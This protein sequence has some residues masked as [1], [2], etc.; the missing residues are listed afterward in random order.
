M[1][2]LKRFSLLRWDNTGLKP[3]V[4]EILFMPTDHELQG[5]IVNWELSSCWMDPAEI[6]LFQQ[7]R[8]PTQLHRRM[9]EGVDIF[10]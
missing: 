10:P 4:N 2:P 8:A 3:G 7:S 9:I 1:K 6:D 5:A